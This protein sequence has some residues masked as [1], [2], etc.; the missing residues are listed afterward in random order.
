MRRWRLRPT[1]SAG[2]AWST[3]TR[4]ARDS[5]ASG[6]GPG[7]DGSADR[8]LRQPGRLSRFR[9]GRP[10]DLRPRQR[11]GP[12]LPDQ[13]AGQTGRL[14]RRRPDVPLRSQGR[15]GVR[16]GQCRRPPDDQRRRLAAGGHQRHRPGLPG[17]VVHG[18]RS[19]TT[20]AASP[21]STVSST[22]RTADC[23]RWSSRIPA[24]ICCRWPPAGRSTSAIRIA[25]WSTS[26][27]TAG[28][29]GPCPPPTGGSS[30]RTWKRTNGCSASASTA[31][32]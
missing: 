14:R 23:T 30:C 5:T 15:R 19:R 11:P 18:R 6:F 32:C 4:A 10:G 31:I 28:R 1:S 27:S 29:T 8:L 17:R 20:A 9:H 26:N 7:T 25:R 12:A 2:G 21:S 13:Q 16:A 22:T 3:T 24:A